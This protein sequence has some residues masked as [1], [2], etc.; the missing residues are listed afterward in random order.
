MEGKLSGT[1]YTAANQ[2]ASVGA[3]YVTSMLP[4]DGTA[5]VPSTSLLAP[6]GDT[7]LATAPILAGNT[8]AIAD[9]A[10]Y[11]QSL[12]PAIPSAGYLSPSPAN[13]R[14]NS[15]L[16]EYEGCEMCHGITTVSG[17]TTYRRKFF[18][19]GRRSGFICRI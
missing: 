4:N 8:T 10:A 5:G 15:I 9:V 18:S 13:T 1:T 3:P 14:G 16:S 17:T 6:S 19:V 2:P 7:A 11:L 12:K